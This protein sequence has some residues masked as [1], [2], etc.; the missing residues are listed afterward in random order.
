MRF[1]P[2]FHAILAAINIYL[3]IDNYQRAQMIDAVMHALFAFNFFV[4][5]MLTNSRLFNE[6]GRSHDDPDR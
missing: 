6:N 2:A 3:V 4:M 1:S 5:F